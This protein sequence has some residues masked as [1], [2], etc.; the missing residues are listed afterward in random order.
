MIAVDDILW[1][2]AFLA[3]ADG[4]GHA[5]FVRTADKEYVFFLQTKITYINVCRD[6]NTGQVT[7]MHRPV[8][9]GEG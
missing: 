2:D 6:I 3:C 9:I 7:D 1:R 8:G 4:D 5:M